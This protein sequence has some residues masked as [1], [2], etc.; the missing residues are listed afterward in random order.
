MPPLLSQN[1]LKQCLPPIIDGRSRVLILGT[2]PGDESLRKQQYYGHPR[3]HFWPVISELVGSP[4]SEFYDARVS[5]LTNNGLGLWDVLASAARS[6]S[7][8]AAIRDPVP[9]DFATLFMQY[10]KLHT[11]AFNGQK[12]HALFRATVMTLMEIRDSRFRFVVLPSTSP[13]HVRPLAEKAA[14]WRELIGSF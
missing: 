10:P 14:Q 7:L 9:N 12:A 2:L 11:L 1:H 8:D 6:G 3:N 4:L 13:A 5:M